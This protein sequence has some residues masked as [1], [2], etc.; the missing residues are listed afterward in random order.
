MA[1]FTVRLLLTANLLSLKSA[2]HFLT[3]SFKSWTQNADYNF[4]ID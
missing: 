1:A 2:L 3:P 4:K